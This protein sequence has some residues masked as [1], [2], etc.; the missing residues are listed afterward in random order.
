MQANM[1]RSHTPTILGEGQKVIFS[2]GHV[3]Y[4]IKGG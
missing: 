4:Q 3:A 1:L 2:E